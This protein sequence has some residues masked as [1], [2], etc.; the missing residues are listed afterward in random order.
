MLTRTY[1][2]N[3]RGSHSFEQRRPLAALFLQRLTG[4]K[5]RS[6]NAKE[7]Q[8]NMKVLGK[9]KSTRRMNLC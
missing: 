4:R 1:D 3:G 6:S 2:E 5:E 7:T 8:L 9:L